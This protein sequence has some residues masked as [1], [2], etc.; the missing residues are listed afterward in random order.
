MID[1]LKGAGARLLRIVMPHDGRDN[2][3]YWRRRASEAGSAAVLWRNPAYN[4]LVRER[5]YEHISPVLAQLP[6]DARVLD[7]GCG[8]GEVTRWLLTQRPD[9]RVT[10][11]DFPEMVERAALEIPASPRLEWV[12]ASADEFDRPGGFDLVLSSGCYSAI[13]DRAR[14]E[15]A[16][17]AGC[18]A[19]APGGRLLLIDPFHHSRY[20]ARVRM[21]ADEVVALVGAQGLQIERCG[22]ILFWPMRDLLS[23]SRRSDATIERW[24]RRGES[25]L[26]RLGERRWSDYKVLQFRKT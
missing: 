10:G 12:G 19:V 3:A 20:L 15:R 22:G 8:T 11:V 26:K 24:F 23:N 13:R 9:L 2:S 7:I 17:A 4:R 21:S 1:L 5:E 16:I 18:R 25:L 6:P 14:C